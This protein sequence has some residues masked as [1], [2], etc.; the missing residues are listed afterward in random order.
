MEAVD[1][2]VLASC[3]ASVHDLPDCPFCDWFDDGV[4]PREA[5]RLALENADG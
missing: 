2:A 5:A 4:S 1:E 3:G